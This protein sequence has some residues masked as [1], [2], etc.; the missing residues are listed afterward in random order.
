M[1]L[2]IPLRLVEID[3]MEAVAE[4]NGVRRT[5]RVD[6][7]REPQVGDYVIVHAGFA[8]ERMSE[9]QALDNLRAI[10]EVADAL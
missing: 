7:I 2:A 10:R 9:R 5:V 6:F 8:M 4:A 1:C 3:G